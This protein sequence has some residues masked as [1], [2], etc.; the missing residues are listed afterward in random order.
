MYSVSFLLVSPSDEDDSY[1]MWVHHQQSSLETEPY[2]VPHPTKNI[3][4]LNHH[5]M[6]SLM[7]YLVNRI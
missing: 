7:N 4:S 5:L 3:V 6:N 2:E 1:E